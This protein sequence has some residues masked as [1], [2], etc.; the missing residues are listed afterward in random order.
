MEAEDPECRV[1][2]SNEVL[3]REKIMRFDKLS[4]EMEKSIRSEKVP[5]DFAGEKTE[6]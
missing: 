3:K 4:V 5:E 2:R 6:L 1:K